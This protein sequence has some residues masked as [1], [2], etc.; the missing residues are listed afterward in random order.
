MG[1]GRFL[2]CVAGGVAAVV[3]APIVLPMAAAAAATAGATALAAGAAA[4]AGAAGTAAAVGTA[5]T[6][7]GTAAAAGVAGAA[8][9]VGT[10]VGTAAA[11]GAGLAGTGAVGTALGSVATIATTSSGAAALGTIAT[12]S[13]VGVGSGIHGANKL[14]EAS[15]ILDAA[16]SKFDNQKD[17]MDHAEKVSTKSLDEFGSIKLTVWDDFQLL[18]DLLEKVYNKPMSEDQV[19]DEKLVLSAIEL[20]EIKGMS[21]TAKDLLGSGI[22]MTGSGALAGLAA[23]GGTMAL[24]AASTGT[25][26]GTLSGAAATNATLA[27]LGGGS[28]ASGGLGM[29]GGATVLGGV[30]AGPAIAVGGILLALKGNDSMEKAEEAMREVNQAV[31]KMKV[32]IEYLNRLKKLTD[33]LA[34]ET[35]RLHNQYIQMVGAVQLTT[36]RT[37]D[38][39]EFEVEEKKNLMNTVLVA[40]LL[41]RVT[42]INIIADSEKMVLN[43]NGVEEILQEV[44]ES[45][46]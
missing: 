18:V 34:K 3:A 23:Y 14:R 4:A 38:Y 45:A 40:K 29:A 26:I 46:C 19:S 11:A 24:G 21:V 17:K 1:F 10:A 36:E 25:M 39:N 8:A 12:T 13:A 6:A 41:K 28:L 7:V 43:E 31:K 22:V 37:M 16:Q 42:Q 15:E 35:K 33:K 32:S 9:T 2:A 5:A 30:V 27:A 20:Q 44:S